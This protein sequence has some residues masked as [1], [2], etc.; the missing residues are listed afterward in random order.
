MFICLMHRMETCLIGC[1]MIFL[2]C[3]SLNK[4]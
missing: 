1:S 2:V 4:C 3:R